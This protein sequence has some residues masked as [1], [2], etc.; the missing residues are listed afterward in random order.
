MILAC[1]R[2][3]Y[4]GS[5][6]F[7]L[8]FQPQHLV[9]IR[10][11]PATYLMPM[12]PLLYLGRTPG[13]HWAFFGS[14]QAS[15]QRSKSSCQCSSPTQGPRWVLASV[16]LSFLTHERGIAVLS[17]PQCAKAPQRLPKAWIPSSEGCWT[18]LVAN[19]T[20]STWPRAY[21]LRVIR[22]MTL[23]SLLNS[24]ST[25]LT[26]DSHTEWV[27]CRSWGPQANHFTFTG[28]LSLRKNQSKGEKSLYL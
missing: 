14:P 28:P 5:K 26:C 18:G 24:P 11:E 10:D 8:L 4:D 3:S 7:Q 1:T 27:A 12:A 17:N 13:L 22:P 21:Q 16:G 15:R 20:G 23:V 6:W 25:G 19:I 9:L 2:V